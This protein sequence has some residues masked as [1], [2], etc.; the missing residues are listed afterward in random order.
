MTVRPPEGP[1]IPLEQGRL[2]TI[3]RLDRPPAPPAGGTGIGVASR[4]R[5][6]AA[7]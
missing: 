4:R 7:S 1:G 2:A 6:A 3:H 5:V